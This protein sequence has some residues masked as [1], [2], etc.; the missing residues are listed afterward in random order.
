MTDKLGGLDQAWEIKPPGNR[1]LFY[2]LSKIPGEGMQ[3]QIVMKAVVAIAAILIIAYF[4]YQISR[5]MDIDYDIVFILSF[6]GVFAISD[7]VMLEVEWFCVLLMMLMIALWL[8]DEW[9][10]WELAGLLTLPLFLMKGISVF[11][12]ITVFAIV[13]LLDKRTFTDDIAFYTGAFWAALAFI[14]LQLT[15]FPHM[16]SDMILS[17]LT[18]VISYDIVTS[19]TRFFTMT[20]TSYMFIPV[21]ATGLALLLLVYYY[22]V[23]AHPKS[24]FWILVAWGSAAA[25]P[26]IQG[27]YFQYQYAGMIIPA[28][29]T[30]L[31]FISL[32]TDWKYVFPAVLCM[33][34]IVWVFFSVG[35]G[36]SVYGYH[37]SYWD[38][39][40]AAAQDLDE[41]YN[42]SGQDTLLYLDPGD[43][44]WYFRSISASRYI[45]PLPVQRDT[46]KTALTNTTA[47]IENCNDIIDY[48]GKY[49]VGVD[50]WFFQNM[51]PD[52]QVIRD[53]IDSEYTMVANSSWTIWERKSPNP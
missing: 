45:C 17:S 19:I 3:Y 23:L 43:A 18:G 40:S 46:N 20:I 16:L 24:F 22:D 4:A 15:V 26:F 30:I 2:L 53:K 38:D 9:L 11:Y 41:K 47:Y 37:T 13:H 52:K 28:I 35:L 36:M 21:I 8:S 6:L 51:T 10:L 7:Y 14:V 12:I 32:K 44:P 29:V 34:M 42:I 31:W 33:I 27:E 49:I 39:R 1:I 48:T 50:W 5:K 25:I